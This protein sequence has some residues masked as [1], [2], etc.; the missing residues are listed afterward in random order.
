M[1]VK[2]ILYIGLSYKETI[3]GQ[4]VHMLRVGNGDV[5]LKGIAPV[6][7]EKEFINLKFTGKAGFKGI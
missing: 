2:W 4:L 7:I 1:Q 5:N 3:S 6:A